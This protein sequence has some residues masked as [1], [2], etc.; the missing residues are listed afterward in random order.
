MRLRDFLKHRKINVARA[1]REIGLPHESVR[2]YVLGERVPRP[3]SMKRIYEWTGG[4]VGPGDYYDL[5]RDSS[6]SPRCG[7]G[8]MTWF[9]ARELAQADLPNFPATQQNVKALAKREGW[10]SR[11]RRARG[12]GREYPIHALPPEAAAA[13]IQ[14]EAAQADQARTLLKEVSSTGSTSLP[15]PNSP[16]LSN[17]L[18]RSGVSSSSAVP[19]ANPAA[20]EA[21]RSVAVADS[22]RPGRQEALTS[23]EARLALLQRVRAFAADRGLPITRAEARY[24][25][26]VRSGKHPNDA[27]LY[28]SGPGGQIPATRTVRAWREAVERD[29]PDA[30]KRQATEQVPPPWADARPPG[31]ADMA[32][33][34]QCTHARTGRKRHDAQGACGPC[35]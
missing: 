31:D 23:M 2:R 8:R 3:E 22:E 13:L 20:L 1:A 10:P 19:A 32:Q 30:L 28:N 11:P 16:D 21:S 29:G 26:E 25:N 33:G 4:A 15:V 7:G 17:S 24:L 9:S 35:L 18:G 5:R 27:Y 34:S 12:G 6:H 14:R